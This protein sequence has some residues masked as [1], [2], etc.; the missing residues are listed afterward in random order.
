MGQYE[1]SAAHGPS[2]F[3]YTENLINIQQLYAKQLIINFEIM[4][5]MMTPVKILQSYNLSL[6]NYTKYP[7]VI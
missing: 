2:S 7:R 3:E 5:K 4:K 6:C 1:I